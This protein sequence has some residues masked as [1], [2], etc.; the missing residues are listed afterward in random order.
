M[1]FCSGDYQGAGYLFDQVLSM[2]TENDHARLMLFLIDWL[3]GQARLSPYRQ[4]LLALDWRSSSE[5]LGHLARILEGLVDQR[6]ALKGWY[7]EDEKSWL[8][9]AVGLMLAKQG[10]P[11]GS[12][13]RLREA[14]LTADSEDWLFF[15]ALSKLEQIQRQRSASFLNTAERT[16]YQAEIEAFT[17]TV[18]KD[19]EAKAKRRTEIAPLIA[20]L[21]Q[22]SVSPKDKQA[23]LERILKSDKTNGNLLVGLVYYSTMDESWDQ[24]LEYARTFLEIEGRENAGRLSI[25]L[26]QPEILHNIGRKEEAKTELER[27]NRRTKDPWYRAIGECLLTQRTE[28][29]L[30]EKAG[31]S[32]EYM[33]TAHTS[34]G[35]W[36]E[37]SGD[38]NKADKHYKEALGSYMDDMIE[39]E[40]ARERIKRLR[41]ISE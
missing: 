13:G 29:S 10:D 37:G 14:V 26:L 34:L 20:K 5:F 2:N 27:Y 15:M 31:E 1:H 41:Q 16:N 25:G 12:E 32:P 28:Q 22:D 8:H 6:S 30:T 36:A 33:L 3:T 39:Y 40:F 17:R 4:E 24:A 21:K 9:Y 35:F 18:Q 19:Q 38:K 11:A 23:V 7:S